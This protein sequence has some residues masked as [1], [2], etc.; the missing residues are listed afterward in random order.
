M[1]KSLNILVAIGTL[2]P[3]QGFSAQQLKGSV[4][5]PEAGII[6]DRQSGFCADSQGISLGFTGI[7]LGVEARQKF[8]KIISS[9]KDFDTTSFVLSNGIRCE[10][11]ARAC[12][13][14]KWEDKIDVA[15]TRALFGSLP[16]GDAAG[17]DMAR[18]AMESLDTSGAAEMEKALR[19]KYGK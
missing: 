16:S 14:S 18:E 17:D 15:H 10:A 1:K 19:E 3:I 11:K 9:V 8:D 2:F 7:Y 6:C 5:S 4:F 13:I 12:Y